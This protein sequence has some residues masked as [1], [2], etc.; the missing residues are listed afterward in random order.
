LIVLARSDRNSV[1]AVK[2][3]ASPWIHHL[4]EAPPDLFHDIQ[5]ALD[6]GIFPCGAVGCFRPGA[7]LDGISAG[8]TGGGGSAATARGEGGG[9]SGPHAVGAAAGQG[10]FFSAAFSRCSCAISPS[11]AARSSGTGRACPAGLATAAGRDLAGVQVEPEIIVA[12]AVKGEPGI[13]EL[14]RLLPARSGSKGTASANAA[15][16]RPE[17]S[18][19]LRQIGKPKF[20][21]TPNKITINL[22]RRTPPRRPP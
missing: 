17:K 6:L 9:T 7:A 4:D 1:A 8:G 22:L 19:N 15:P 2:A 18:G 10:A 13:A 12:A 11:S 14:R 5:G 21:S 20:K 16:P 3:V